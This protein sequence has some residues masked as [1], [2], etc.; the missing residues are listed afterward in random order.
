M[1]DA[2]YAVQFTAIDI[3]AIAEALDRHMNEARAQRIFRGFLRAVKADDQAIDIAWA[4]AQFFENLISNQPDGT[5]GT[6]L[7]RS[8]ISMVLIV[9]SY[10]ER[11][12][13]KH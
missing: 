8:F 12:E 2:P 1:S 4:L 3:A 10:Q 9:K 6:D 5:K 13:V 11:R 7:L